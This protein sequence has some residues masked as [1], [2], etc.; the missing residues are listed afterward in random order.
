MTAPNLSLAIDDLYA[1]TIATG[2]ITYSHR[3]VLMNAMGSPTLKAKERS[4]IDR[5]LQD[6]VNGCLTVIDE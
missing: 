4:I 3:R 2:K 5:L 1:R 6:S